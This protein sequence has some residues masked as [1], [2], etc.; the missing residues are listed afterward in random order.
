MLTAVVWNTSSNR[1]TMMPMAVAAT[2]RV[3]NGQIIQINGDVQLKRSLG[4]IIRPTIG[5]QVYPGDELLT[6]RGAQVLVQCADLKMWSVEAGENRLNSCLEATEEAE[7]TPGTYKCPHRGDDIAWNNASIPYVI[8]PRRT[9][10][11][12][13]KPTLRWNPVAGETNYTVSIEGEGVNWT[14]QV[15]SPQVI[16][17]GE[18]PLKSGSSYLLMVK[19]NSTGVSSL[20][21]PV[22]PGGLNFSLLGENQAQLVRAAKE[23]IEQQKWTDQA[24]SLVLAHLYTKN[25]LISE[26]ITTLEELVQSGVQTAPIYR[27]LGDLYLNYLALVPQARD[28][29]SKAVELA[30]SNN[31]EERT[32]AQDGLG[33]VQKALG[34][35]DEA[36]RW[37]TQAR[38]GYKSLGDSERA[39][40]LEKQLKELVY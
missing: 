30:S 37:L 25:D 6:A 2:R 36:V 5:T 17:S 8:S 20:D 10:L 40:A 33:Q 3:S 24:K 12:S 28:Y 9:A 15:S 31:L 22:R 4:R 18:S 21:E 39:S 34:N 16:Y 23:Q 38:D 13:D 32:A 35:K 26:A 14:T 7:C 19:A 29:Y 1:G 11:L 27:T